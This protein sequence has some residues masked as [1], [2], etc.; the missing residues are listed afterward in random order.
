M[1]RRVIVNRASPIKCD[2]ND[3]DEDEF[4]AADDPIGRA[5]QASGR[6]E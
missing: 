5:V 3:R 2:K 4:N 6:R 1:H